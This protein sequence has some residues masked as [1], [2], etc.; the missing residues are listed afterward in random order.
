MNTPIKC[1]LTFLLSALGISVS[2]QND[3]SWLATYENCTEYTY[4]FINI[5][6]PTRG[7]DPEY[8]A[9][10]TFSE[11]L[12]AVKMGGKWGF[13]NASNQVVIDFQYDH[14]Y[15][16]NAGNAIVQQGNF[17][18]VINQEGTLVVPIHYYE[19]RPYELEGKWYYISR[20]TTFFQGIIDTS[21]KEIVPHRY[22]YIIPFEGNLSK[23]RFYNNISFSATYREIDPAKGSFMEQ[24][25]D[26]PF[27][28]TPENGRHDIYDTRFNKL[29][30]KISTSYSDGFDHSELTDIDNYLENHKEIGIGQEI[31]ESGPTPEKF[32]VSEAELDTF[33]VQIGYEKFTGHDGKTGVKKAGK[34]IL[35]AEFDILKWWIMTLS[36]PSK[37]AVSYLEKHYAGRYR[38]NEE[39]TYTVFGIAAGNKEKGILYT[40][41]GNQVIALENKIP[42]RATSAGFTYRTIER[43]TIRQRTRYHFG[44]V[45]WEGRQVLP[46]IYTRI[47]PVSD[48]QL[49]V[50]REIEKAEDV[51]VHSALYSASGTIIIPEGVFSGIEP[52]AKI[53]NLYLAERHGS[54]PTIAEQKTK[55]AENKQF[56]LL[57]VKGTT[58]SIKD[59]FTAT[60]VYTGGLDPLTG[61]LGYKVKKENNSG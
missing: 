34:I 60:M 22:T 58:Y 24:F 27:E 53:P 48:D 2:A 10:N 7:I 46:P 11:G 18:G 29:A 16:F 25:E 49:L 23:G 4:G 45:N 9:A 61:M 19:L 28:F 56:V 33:M 12:A 17:Y 8:C 15:H 20:D 5:Q 40:M 26:N 36:S 43:D 57:E 32:P 6:D 13:I 37:A 31:T 1:S 35:T 47:Q 41:K 59:Q 50:E 39:R 44:F 55:T 3:G 38:D 51:E 42:E 14:A 54:Y 52:L 21:G 30:S